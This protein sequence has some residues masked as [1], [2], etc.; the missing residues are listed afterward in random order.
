MSD[1]RLLPSL[2]LTALLLGGRV[3]AGDRMPAPPMLATGDLAGIEVRD[4]WV[5]EKLD[6]VRGHW[7][8]TRLWTRGGH[9]VR[10]PDWFTQGWPA[11]PMDGELWMGR[12]QFEST[13]ALVRSLDAAKDPAWRDVR[14]M[15]FDLPR[16]DDVFEVRHE[17]LRKI[18]GDADVAWLRVVPQTRVSTRKA[19]DAR[20]ASV[21]ARGGEGLMLHHRDARYRPGRSDLL[22]KYKR[23]DD[24]EARVVAHLP[25][26]GKYA[27][28]TGSLLVESADGRRFRLGSGLSDAQRADP[29]RIGAWVTYRHDGLTPNGLPRFARFLRVRDGWAPES[30]E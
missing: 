3:L 17:R 4:W 19:L 20:L 30:P 22:V 27:G 10:A 13:S 25:G 9:V 18:V 21:E 28:M 12:G 14:F 16:H 6:G 1:R 8:G 15:A 7:D 24:A 11:T 26:Q 2:V 29:P 5:S 23:H